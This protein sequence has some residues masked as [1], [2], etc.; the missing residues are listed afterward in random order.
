MK[1]FL[2]SVLAL[3]GLLAAGCQREREA[4][5][6]QPVDV[7]FQIG[8]DGITKAIGDGS[9]ALLLTLRIYDQQG[10]FVQE[11][12]A[13]RE[14]SESG[15]TVSAAIVPGTYSFCFWASS[16]DSGAYGFDGKFLTVDY[17]KM[18]PNSD[19]D[20]AFWAVLAG[21]EVTAAFTESV[22][23]TRPLAQISLYSK[24]KH[25]DEL[26]EE[27]LNNASRFNSSM[28]L[29]GVS[30]SGI[31]TRMNLLDGSTDTPLAQV[32]FNEAPL[33][34][35]EQSEDNGTLVAFAYVLVPAEGLTLAEVAY[36]AP[37][38]RTS[39]VINLASG[40]VNNVPLA[41]NKRTLLVPQAVPTT[42]QAKNT[43]IWM[44]ANSMSAVQENNASGLLSI[45]AKG[46]HNIFLSSYVVDLYGSEAVNSFIDACGSYEISVHFVMNTLYNGS[47]INP[48]KNG[49]FNETHFNSLAQSV[50]YYIENLNISGIVLDYLRYPGNAYNTENAA[51]AV[52]RCCEV[53]SDAMKEYDRDL[54]LSVV[55]MPETTDNIY[56]YGQDTEALSQFADVLIPMLY[57]GNYNYS[58]DWYEPTANWF[59]EKAGTR[60][61]VWPAL[62]SYHSDSD[63]SALSEEEFLTEWS[64]LKGASFSGLCI[65]RYGIGLLPDVSNLAGSS[66]N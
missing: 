37:L 62:L 12:T 11:S 34:V 58:L 5:S 39:P 26:G 52:T 19:Q 22:T 17:S 38:M 54:V 14:E 57:R 64:G 2:F 1:R 8:M 28:V 9:Q 6:G 50:K 24:D 41:R 44:S 29:D 25:C 23:L 33:T 35:L 55:L 16:P 61:E 59:T 36:S 10:N 42:L 48:V 53:I 21:K 18:K 13:D 60:A 66:G 31:P 49:E 4:V 40:Y 30:G 7:S 63:T 32:L 27:D 51:A 20:D 47:W 45:S 43:A 3:A 56:Y 15:W 65:Y 46:F